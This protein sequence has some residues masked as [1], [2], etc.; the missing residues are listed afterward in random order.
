MAK[1]ASK[2]IKTS[3]E[4]NDF[5]QYIKGLIIALIVTFASVIIFALII[6]WTNL[7]DKY[8]AP[9]NLVIKALSIA[10]GTICF[11]KSKTGGLKKGLIFAV[12]YVSLAFVVFSALSGSFNMGLSLL[13]DYLFSAVVGAIVGIIRVNAKS[14]TI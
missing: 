4:I 11:T 8:I 10:I 6:K 5:V 13:L 1:L 2:K 12:S 7:D 14:K 3:S 9:V